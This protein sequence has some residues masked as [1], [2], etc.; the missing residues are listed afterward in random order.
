[1]ET[2]RMTHKREDIHKTY[3]Q[4]IGG[5]PTPIQLRETFKRHINEMT[6]QVQ[7]QTLTWD[8]N[9]QDKTMKNM[10]RYISEKDMQKLM[11]IQ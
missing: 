11:R 7:T 2:K 6:I 10:L 8:N 3:T 1:M 9:L 4:Y 5:S